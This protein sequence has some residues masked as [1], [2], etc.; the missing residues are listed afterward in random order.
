MLL[1]RKYIND[2]TKELERAQE[3]N[4][5]CLKIIEFWRERSN[6]L[7]EDIEVKEDTIENLLDANKELS[8]AN[9]YLEKQNIS[10]AKENAMLEK[11]LQELKTKH[12]RVIGQLDKLRNYCRQLTGIDILGTGEDE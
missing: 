8:L 6:E 2:L 5:D 3:T 12:S 10:F 4:K 9:T 11:E 1:N 7:K